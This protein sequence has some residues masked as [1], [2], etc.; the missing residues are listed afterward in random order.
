VYRTKYLPVTRGVLSINEK[1]FKLETKTKRNL[2]NLG[3][4]NLGN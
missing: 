4:N 1:Q 3:E 2:F